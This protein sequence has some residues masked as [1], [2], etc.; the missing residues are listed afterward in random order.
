MPDEDQLFLSPA[1]PPRSDGA[2][3]DLYG[4]ADDLDFIM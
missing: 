4:I 3:V 1:A 2:G